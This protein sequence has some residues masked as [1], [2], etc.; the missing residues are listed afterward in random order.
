MKAI[1]LVA[2]GTVSA[3]WF[4]HG[5]VPKLLYKHPDEYAPLLASGFSPESAEWMVK[6][7]GVAEIAAA[8][9]LLLFW[10]VRIGFWITIVL[11]AAALVS[12]AFTS[13]HLLVAAF[14][15]VSLNLSMIALSAIG[16]LSSPKDNPNQKS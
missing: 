15:P 5:L 1:Y 8:A 6:A 14:N 7:A 11:M 13:P 4:Y 3:I 12:V 10:R 16:L 9:A 2:R